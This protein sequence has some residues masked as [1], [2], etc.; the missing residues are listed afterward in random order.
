MFFW[1]C[2]VLFLATWCVF[3]FEF[4]FLLHSGY[5]SFS[6]STMFL[7]NPYRGIFLFFVLVF[8]V[9]CVRANV[10]VYAHEGVC[11][12]VCAWMCVW[13]HKRKGQTSNQSTLG[14]HQMIEWESIRGTYT[15]RER[16]HARARFW[17]W[18][19]RGWRDREMRH[20]DQAREWNG[21]RK[22]RIWRAS[23]IEQQPR[24]FARQSK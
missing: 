10:C 2:C 12:C 5:L 14:C 23:D 7:N 6:L 9:R 3:C 1:G 15:E 22:I 11:V 20:K 16:L 13:R 8:V 19:E 18:R 17:R 21:K 24:Q 4:S